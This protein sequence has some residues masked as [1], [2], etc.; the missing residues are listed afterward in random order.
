MVLPAPFGPSSASILPPSTASETPS[1]ATRS[2]KRL[3]TPRASTTAG[4]LRSGGSPLGRAGVLAELVELAD[5]PVALLV[6]VRVGVWGAEGRR[7]LRTGKS[8]RADRPVVHH[9]RWR[10][11]LHCVTFRRAPSRDP[12]GTSFAMLP[13]L[14]SSRNYTSGQFPPNCGYLSTSRP[15]CVRNSERGEDPGDQSR[16]ARA[17]ELGDRE[18]PRGPERDA[19]RAG[20]ELAH[21]AANSLPSG[22][23]GGGPVRER[24]AQEDGDPVLGD[25]LAELGAP[26]ARARA[27][28]RS[29]SAR[30]A[31]RD[32]P[33]RR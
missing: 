29:T 4:A 28:R 2:P 17:G 21:R 26:R 11:P 31:A 25:D 15:D 5:A 19:V 32:A 12:T 3:E 27:G 7:K 1:S 16:L 18:G 13:S 9:F 14:D 8:V 33:A 30:R 6:L 20:D 22:L 10:E 23:H 24:P